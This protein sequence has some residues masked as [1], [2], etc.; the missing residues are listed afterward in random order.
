MNHATQN[1]KRQTGT[2]RR[3]SAGAGSASLGIVTKTSSTFTKPP[4]EIISKY[5]EII[6]C[7][8]K[9]DLSLRL[10]KSPQQARAERWAFKSVVNQLL[11]NSRTSKCMR[12][13]SP[14]TG[15]G[16]AWIQVHKTVSTNKAFYMGLMSCGSVWICPICA[17]K[18]S[19]RRRQELIQAISA[20]KNLGWKCHLVTLTVPHG[21]GDD[22]NQ[23]K[24][25]QQ[26]ALTKLSSGRSSV[27][28]QLL[29]NGIVQHGYIRAYEV[30]HGLNGFH[31]HFHILLF[32]SQCDS[33]QIQNLYAPAWQ[34][35]CVSVGLPKPSDKHGCIT[36]DG[37][38]AAKYA[39]KWGI[40][41]ELSK[42]NTKINKQKGKSP[43]G[44]LRAVL[45]ENDPDYSPKKASDLFM[46]YARCMK[47][48]RQLYWSNGLRLIL[49]MANELTDKQLAEQITDESTI[50]MADITM[51]QW[52]AI[53][54]NKAEP[55]ILTAAESIEETNRYLLFEIINGHLERSI[56]DPEVLNGS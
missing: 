7:E 23:I 55:H 2:G 48:A 51:P 45:D 14:V 19:E 20:S 9:E 10:V 38:Q 56:T 49:A 34:K 37:S 41:D 21:I 1:R 24:Q 29:R 13:L 42:A 31:P 27:K 53:R 4:F 15:C 44:L 5:G 47:G 40:E 46:V 39:S 16:L 50:H 32:T 52:R 3:S 36:H 25:L 17:A 33:Q 6:E 18:V 26:K 11:P 22:L 54:K 8:Q 28:S 35:A 12:F 43:W 30:T